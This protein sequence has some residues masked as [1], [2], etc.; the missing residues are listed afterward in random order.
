MPI[1]PDL[2]H[3]YPANWKEIRE[4]ILARA[5]NRCER[6]GV[7]NYRVGFWKAGTWVDLTLWDDFGNY[8]KTYAEAAYQRKY[9]NE[10]IQV[11]QRE[12]RR[13]VVV[14][15]TIAHINDPSPENCA[16]DNLQ[17]LCQKCHNKLDAP[18]RATNRSKTR[19][20]KRAKGGQG[21]IGLR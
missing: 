9:G 14:V 16:D 10:P 12:G 8:P 18:M 13:L 4:R 6:C 5:K 1:R 7:D 20:M 21:E 11:H 17:A 19:V 3:R 15:L 2:K